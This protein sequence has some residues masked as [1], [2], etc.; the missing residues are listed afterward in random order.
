MKPIIFSE[1]EL[2]DIAAI[3]QKLFDNQ[4]DPRSSRYIRK[5]VRPRINWFKV[6]FYL[7]LPIAIAGL[8]FYT[9]ARLQLPNWSLKLSISLYLA[10]YFWLTKKRAAICLIRI[11]QRYA[12]SNLRN[13]CR[14][15]PSCSEYMILAIQK[16][17]FFAGVR[18][19]VKRLK[20][21]NIDS[22]GYDYP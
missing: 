8:I 12:P 14:F 10:L 15:E 20:R 4:D 19:G 5:L 17:G 22:G 18:K 2:N 3:G 11:Y 1:N 6:L 13:K 9:V 21:C 16:F 7:T